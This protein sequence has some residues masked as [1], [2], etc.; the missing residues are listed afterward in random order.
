MQSTSR[1]TV[2]DVINLFPLEIIIRNKSI[3]ARVNGKDNVVIDSSAT[4][5]E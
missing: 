4:T 5:G 2:F 1:H 3:L